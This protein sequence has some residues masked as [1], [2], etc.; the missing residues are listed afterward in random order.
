MKYEKPQVAV[1]YYNL[2]QGIAACSIKISLTDGLCVLKDEDSTPEMK[3][4]VFGGYFASGCDQL[5]S[6]E[7]TNENGTC[8]M[9]N[10]NAAF[11]S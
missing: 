3:D 7:D 6:Y 8:Y 9:Y 10:H 1:E 4:M 2:S 5:P 11:N